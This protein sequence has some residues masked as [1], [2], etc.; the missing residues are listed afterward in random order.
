MYYKVCNKKYQAD[1]EKYLGDNK[2][3]LRRQ[4]KMSAQTAMV[5]L[6]RVDKK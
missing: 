6:G 5:F 3:S 1:T 4:E 2:E